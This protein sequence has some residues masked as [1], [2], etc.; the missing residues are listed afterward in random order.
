M[1]KVCLV[2]DDPIM[3]ESLQ[4]RFEL[5]GVVC[6]W[7]QS[8]RDALGPLTRGDYTA[9]ISDIR[10]PDMSGEQ[11]FEQLIAS[12]V[13]LLPTL[14][15]TGYGTVDQAVRLLKIG[16]SDYITKP[17][18]LDELLNKLRNICPELYLPDDAE[19]AILGISEPI[20]QIE[21]KLQRAVRFPVPILITGDSGVGKEH[22]ARYFRDCL[23]QGKDIPFVSINC[24]AV[25]ESLLEAELFGHEKGAFTG[26]DRQRQGL[27]EQADGGVLFLD[28]LGEMS[29]S[30]QAKL[31]RS[32]QESIV[33]RVGG[34]KDIPVSVRIVCA[35]NKDLSTMIDEGRFREDLYYRINV[36]T[37]HLPPLSERREDIIW[38]AHRLVKGCNE[39]DSNTRYRLTAAAESWL[40]KQDW[41]GNIRQLKNTIER[42][43]IYADSG[44]L[45][46]VL[47]ESPEL[48]G[49]KIS[50][51]R[52]LRE[53]VEVCERDRI[54]D[55]LNQHEGRIFDTAT[56][57][58]ISRKN[59]WEKMRKYGL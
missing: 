50:D 26:A 47:F 28:E 24:A 58:G 55:E 16:A 54:K 23:A 57:L 29:L 51:D 36:V 18:D 38:F 1:V 56:A 39:I 52:S 43:C 8:A 48:R 4:Q 10:L 31:L 30:M 12:P 46:A 9:L 21:R 19:E 41:P 17:F 34:V 22:A 53:Y 3:G 45:E 13:G 44:R 14:F 37:V 59:L 32:L 2:E 5:E 27:F 11:L 15:M 6:D 20:R 42:A 25:Q 40:V 35:T 33:R 7:Y 49:K